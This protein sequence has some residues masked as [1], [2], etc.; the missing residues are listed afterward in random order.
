MDIYGNKVR[1]R[2]MELS[3]C[4]FVRE[5]FNDPQMEQM[6]VG[7]AFPLSQYAQEQWFMQHYNDPDMRFVIETEQGEPIGIATLLEIDWK[8]KMAQHGIKLAGKQQRGKG[9]GT[10][11]VMAIMRYAF[12][13]LGLHR[14]NGAWFPDNEA[15]KAMYMKCGWKEE[16][17]RRDYIYKNGR[18]RDLVETG[19]LAH[20][21][22]ALV[23]QNHYWEQA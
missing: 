6:V 21:Y 20:E 1:L 2:A 11:A 12:D 18:Y 5:M 14:L 4:A 13:E 3:D 17:V 7:W 23:A 9:Y 16:G 19:I 8:N 15:S 10:D 22:Y